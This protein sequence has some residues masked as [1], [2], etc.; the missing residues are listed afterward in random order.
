M[1]DWAAAVLIDQDCEETLQAIE[2]ANLQLLEFRHIDHRLD[3]RVT[4]A[5]R[6]VASLTRSVLP[7]WRTW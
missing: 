5:Q 1:P 6:F 3:D 4:A 7:F 2:F